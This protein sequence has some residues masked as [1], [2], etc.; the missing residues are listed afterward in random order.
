MSRLGIHASHAPRRDIFVVRPLALRV[1]TVVRAPALRRAV[2]AHASIVTLCRLSR[3]R[4]PRGGRLLLALLPLLLQLLL[5]LFLGQVM[6][7][8]ATRSCAH[9]CMMSRHMTR[10]AANDGALNAALCLRG[11]RSQHRGS[12]SDHESQS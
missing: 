10:D 1:V 2:T 11:C 8:D 7:N 4:L 5:L 9:D 12:R 6:A 3:A